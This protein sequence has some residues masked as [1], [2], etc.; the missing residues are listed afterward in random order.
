PRLPP[1]PGKD[2]T[3]MMNWPEI[4]AKT[5]Q[6]ERLCWAERQRMARAIQAAAAL[7]HPGLRG[8]ALARLGGWLVHEGTRLQ[9]QYPQG[10][11][12]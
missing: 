9:S 11:R 12:N 6:A 7:E 1:K 2:V 4:E 8:R 3:G 5:R 10:T